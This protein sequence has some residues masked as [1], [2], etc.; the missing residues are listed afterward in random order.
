LAV[1]DAVYYGGDC[2]AGSKTIAVNL[3]NDEIIQQYWGTRRSQLK[4]TMKAKFDAIV[5]PISKEMIH[6]SQQ[7]NINFDAFFNNVMF[8]E[9]AHGLGVKN[10]VSDPTKT[11]RE[12]LGAD[13]SAI[14]ECKADVLGLYMVTSLNEAGVLKGNLDDFYVTF[15][16]SVYRSVRFGASSAHGRANMII[17]NTLMQ[18]GCLERSGKG[19]KVN[20]GLMKNAIRELATEL[21][22]LQGDG[23]RAAVTKMLTERGSIDASL[24][25]EL[26]GIQKKKI[27]VDIVFEQGIKVLGLERFE[28]K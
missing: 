28:T 24:E 11:V 19:L 5:M 20:V 13:Y 16:A 14:E 6:K 7:K 26:K 22:H 8:H 9:V 27:P 18:K 25:L 15:V 10:L 3:P 12:A 21:L 4:N 17:F 2:N 23:D 1:F